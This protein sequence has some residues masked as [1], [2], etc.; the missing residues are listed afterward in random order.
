LTLAKLGAV[1][2]IELPLAT[3]ELL[4]GHV[5]ADHLRVTRARAGGHGPHEAELRLP[6]PL[7]ACLSSRDP[8][9]P[10]LLLNSLVPAALPKSQKSPKSATAQD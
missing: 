10:P 9:S 3:A 8:T 1:F 6:T 7:P 4:D 5:V 2:P